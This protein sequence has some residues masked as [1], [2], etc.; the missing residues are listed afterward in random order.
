MIL[1]NISKRIAVILFVMIAS[2]LSVFLYDFYTVI[3]KST[4]STAEEH[5][6]QNTRTSSI[7]VREKIQGDLD[8][9]Y[10][11]ASLLSGFDSIDSLEAKALLKKVGIEYPFSLLLVQSKD[12]SYYTSSGSDINIRNT[13]Y[14]IGA[15]TRDTSISMIYKNALYNR[16]MIALQSNIYKD[17]TMIGT[18]SGLYYTNYINN[19]LNTDENKNTHQYQIVDR[20]GNFILASGMSVFDKYDDLYSF[21]AD[22]GFKKE[23]K[24]TVIRDFIGDRPGA[25]TFQLN[26]KTNYFCYTPIGINDWYLVSQAP[27]LALN[28]QT[29]SMQNPT[30]ML[31]LQII[32]LFIILILYIIWRQLRYRTAMEASRNEL[33]MLNERLQA[34]NESLKI[35]AEND[36]LTELYNKVTSELVITDF[37]QN[38]GKDGRHALFVID[39]DDFKKINDE[40]G[41]IYGDKALTDVADGINHCLRTTDIKGRI[42]G[43][44]FIILLK[45][46]KTDA[47]IIQKVTEISKKFNSIPVLFGSDWKIGASIGISVYPDHSEN[48]TE[49]FRKADKAMYYSKEHGKGTYY[50]YN[51]EIEN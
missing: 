49:L 43:D 30:I 35:K 9:I 47:D 51:H 2:T 20:D 10:T 41:H 3:S 37:L 40:L 39:L 19:I 18:V 8:T 26:N 16:D 38:D 14:L 1:E 6:I 28:L 32:I 33:E 21:L 5:L 15:P 46:I 17:G 48:F 34:K 4:I 42:G 29:V 27:E 44:E 31:A 22:S 12:G 25:T 13:Q 23:N 11:L 36:L 45:Y 24:D 50:I 7:M